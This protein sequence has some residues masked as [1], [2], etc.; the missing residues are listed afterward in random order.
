MKKLIIANAFAAAAISGAV[1]IGRDLAMGQ[2]V[3]NIATPEGPNTQGKCKDVYLVTGINNGL[4][5]VVVLVSAGDG[6][7]PNDIGSA[8]EVSSASVWR[9]C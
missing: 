9:A 1:I 6:R 2:F 7:D 8:Y 3:T 4:L 5:P